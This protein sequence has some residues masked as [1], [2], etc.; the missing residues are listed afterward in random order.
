M[1]PITLCPERFIVTALMARRPL[2]LSALKVF[3]V[4]GVLAGLSAEREAGGLEVASL[5]LALPGLVERFLRGL[6]DL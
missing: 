4:L 6:E 1:R 5:S 3:G 2:I